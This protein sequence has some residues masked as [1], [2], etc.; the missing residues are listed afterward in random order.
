MRSII[1]LRGIVLRSL[2]PALHPTL[3]V[4]AIGTLSSSLVLLVR[5]LIV[6]FNTARGR[7][8]QRR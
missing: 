5:E 1:V 7:E 3:H 2:H 8:L 6:M 4:V